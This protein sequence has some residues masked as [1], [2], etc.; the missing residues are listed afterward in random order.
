MGIALGGAL[1]MDLAL[2]DRIDTDLEQLFL[3]NPEPL[4]ERVPERIAE[5]D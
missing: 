1:L 4:G 5:D 3:V 2:A